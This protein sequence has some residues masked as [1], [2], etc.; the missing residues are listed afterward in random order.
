MSLNDKNVVVTGG[1]RGLGLGLVESLVARGARVTVVA[2]SADALKAVRTRLGVATIAADVTDEMAAR[3][4]VAET[5]P[6][7][8]ALN[9]GAKP[10]MG[11]LDQLSWQDFTTN[12]EVDVRAG[13]FWVQAALQL[14]L[15][16]GS[17]VL[18]SSSGAA[19][20]GSPLS[21]GYA[22]AKRMLW[23]M[24][25]YANTVA[26]QKRLG[27]RFQAIVPQQMFGGTG[28]G[29]VGAAAYARAN[30]IDPETF[31]ARSFTPMSP[32]EFGEQ[33]VT[34]LEDAHD[35]QSVAIGIRGDTGVSVIEGE[36]A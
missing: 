30:G 8:L 11:R 19:Q 12:W 21:G 36:A 1:S 32:R 22:G 9:A 16:P 14:P 13:F 33:V 34:L 28:V 10:C 27:I 29:D 35:T 25:K 6:H 18:L 24:A 3:R 26:I 17:R 2:R 5:R 7:V 15:G 31:L 23:F 20:T 4:I